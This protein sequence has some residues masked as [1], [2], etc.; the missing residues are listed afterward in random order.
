VRRATS[1]E[2]PGE[3]P[4]R[5]LTERYVRALLQRPDDAFALERL[6]ELSLARDGSLDGLLARFAREAERAPDD[7][8]VMLAR[9]RVLALAGRSEEAVSLLEQTAARGS[10][11]ER[12]R[13]QLLRAE[14]L[15]KLGRA[16]EA[17]AAYEALKSASDSGTRVHALRA[18]GE[19]ALARSD[20]AAA[21]QVFRELE[22]ASPHD[23]SAAQAYPRAL[24]A[25]GRHREAAEAYLELARRMAGDPRA[26]VPVLREAARAA[27]E[28]GDAELART[29]LERALPLASSSL[30]VELYDLLVEAERPLGR[31]DELAARLAKEAGREPLLLSRVAR[32]W[33]ELGREDEALSAYRALLRRSPRDIDTRT[34]LARLLARSGRLDELLHEYETLVAMA[35]DE[36]SFVVAY[37]ELLRERGEREKALSVLARASQ[38]APRSLALHRALADLYTQWGVS[39]AAQ[40]ELALL[41]RLDPE[42]S[43]HVIAL[44]DEAFERGDKAQAQHIWERLLEGHGDRADAHATYAGVLGD[45]GLFDLAAEQYQKALELKPTRVDYRRSQ[46]SLLERA[47]KAGEAEVAWQWVLDH[48]SADAAVRREARQHLVGIWLRNGL[49]ARRAQELETRFRGPPPDLEAGRT[50]AELYARDPAKGAEELS[51]LET[52]A[53]LDARDVETLRALERAYTRRGALD[54]AQSTLDRLVAADPSSAAVYLGRAVELSL[55]RYRDDEALRYAERA[56]KIRPTDG[57]VHRLLGD[58]FRRRQDLA[59]AVKAYERAAE[60]DRNDYDTRLLLAQ[61]ATARGDVETALRWLTQVVDASPD[62]EQV[63]RAGRAAMQLSLPPEARGRLELVLLEL[64]LARPERPLYRRLLVESYARRLGLAAEHVRRGVATAAENDELARVGT[65]SI[66]PLLE[67]LADSDP[68]QREAALELLG[69][70]RV[71][72]AGGPL[73]ALAEQG[74]NTHERGAAL[75][76]VG[77]IH[78]P[79]LAPRLRKLVTRGE[80]RM[81]PVALWALAESE[82]PGAKDMLLAR[83]RSDRDVSVRVMCALLL[84]SLGVHEAVPQLSAAARE[85]HAALRASALWSLGRLDP[86]SHRALFVESLSAPFPA[87]LVA[88]SAL[89]QDFDVLVRA[90]ASE[91]PEQRALSVRLLSEPANDE[92]AELPVPPAP[93]VARS[94]VLSLLMPETSVHA[95]AEHLTEVWPEL[96]AALERSLRA[97]VPERLMVLGSLRPYGGGLVPGALLDEGVCP[98]PELAQKLGRSLRDA[99]GALVTDRAFRGRETALALLSASGGAEHPQVVSALASGDAHLRRRMLDAMLSAPRLSPAVKQEL[100]RSFDHESDW[101]TRLRIARLLG[102][103]LGHDRLGREPM[104]IVKAAASAAAQTTAAPLCSERSIN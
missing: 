49:A 47:G 9:A 40:S 66:K 21:A 102:S 75:A 80:R 48:G 104:P 13:T 41:A 82:G 61:L 69:A 65:S 53:T 14:L 60:L 25:A 103:E 73:M 79:S 77:L 32:L 64:C 1:G 99:L 39:E 81:L 56:V 94:Y 46:A 92:R 78:D 27:I 90:L 36:A 91:L 95:S 89:P 44:G 84:G 2:N 10:S 63:S 24:S 55:A 43:S 26:S 16:D 62:D 17:R 22:R 96:S 30:K 34:R 35:P 71:R 52:L 83:L 86:D 97:D 87:S 59:A 54:K 76:A 38:R 57:K 23:P 85:R 11:Q 28:A 68:S 74:E 93:F 3:T 100:L 58:L 67:A 6:R 98:P 33:D 5:D 29:T 4:Q 37:A 31:L 8:R 15:Q 18:L 88:L 12:T 51:M 50:L 42:D 70:A 20:L 7:M 72:H 19:L 45:H 101:P